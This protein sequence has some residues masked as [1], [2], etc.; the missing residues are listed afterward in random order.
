[1]NTNFTTR[2]YE[3]TNDEANASIVFRVQVRTGNGSTYDGSLPHI[4]TKHLV[5][6]QLTQNQELHGMELLPP[7]VL[8]AKFLPL[9]F[10]ALDI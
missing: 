6:G 5:D 7:V 4:K 2:L 3:T 8:V 9:P 1:M 10:L